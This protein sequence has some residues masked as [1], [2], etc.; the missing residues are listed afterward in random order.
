M[1]FENPKPA[2]AARS[3]WLVSLASKTAVAK[4]ACAVGSFV[5][6]LRTSFKGCG[7][8]VWTDFNFASGYGWLRHPMRF[9]SP[10]PA[11]L[12]PM[13]SLAHSRSLA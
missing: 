7:E 1:I 4:R 3:I 5:L 6:P 10:D 13:N 8:P 12:V 11:L 2:V 9:A